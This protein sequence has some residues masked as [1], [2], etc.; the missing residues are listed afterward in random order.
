M[1]LDAGPTTVRPPDGACRTR[2]HARGAGE[3]KHDELA[4]RTTGSKR[5]ARANGG[6]HVESSEMVNLKG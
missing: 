2:L 3:T 5:G 1:Q 4:I 6:I